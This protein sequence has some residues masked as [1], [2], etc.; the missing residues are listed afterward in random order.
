MTE[1]GPRISVQY[2][3][4]WSNLLGLGHDAE[5]LELLLPQ[6]TAIFASTTRLWE[7][8]VA[9]VGMAPVFEGSVDDA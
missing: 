5:H 8:D 9:G 4:A 1:R 3:Q 6:I 7:I 2:L